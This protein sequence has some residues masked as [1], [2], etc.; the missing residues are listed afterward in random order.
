MAVIAGVDEAGKGPVIGPMVVAGVAILGERIPE[1]ERLGLRDSKLHTPL[2][3]ES[4]ASKIKLIAESYE[5]LISAAEIDSQSKSKTMNEIAVDCFAEVLNVLKPARAFVDAPD[6]KPERFA[7][8]LAAIVNNPLEITSEHR[9]DEKYPVVSAA[10]IIA[11]VRRDSEIEKIKRDIGND[12]GSGYPADEKTVEFLRNL[13]KKGELPDYVRHSWKT[14][15]N[16]RIE[17]SQRNFGDY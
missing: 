15:I 10:S 13:V 12:F 11:K 17:A 7:Q 5:F 14:V 9:A 2:Q 3:R 16:M 4:L 1:L 8:N 6:V